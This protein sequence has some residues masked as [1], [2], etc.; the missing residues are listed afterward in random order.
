[1]ASA[2]AQDA[3][4][5]GRSA[6]RRPP[7]VS[8]LA[9]VIFLLMQPTPGSAQQVFSTEP[10]ALPTSPPS[11]IDPL[12]LPAALDLALRRN[13]ELQAAQQ[14]IRAM[15]AAVL[16][17][18]ARLNP[19]V[20]ASL[21]DLR[22]ETRETTVQLNQTL[23]LGGKRTARIG[24]AERGRDAA[25][26]D[27][28]VRRAEIRAIVIA[29]FF[30]LLAAQE[31]VRLAQSSVELAQR[32]TSVAANRVAAGKVSP[33]EETKARVAEANV[34]LELNQA[35]SE[36]AIA[37]Q[38]LAATWGDL[39][40]RF[41][42]AS[43]QL[44]TLPALPDSSEVAA[45]MAKAPALARARSEVDHRLAL[46][47][48]EK[49][50]RTPNLTVGAGVKRVEELGRNQAVLAVSIPLPLFDQNR[51]NLLEALHRA[52]KARDE[53]AATSIRLN[54]E[55]AQA[56]ERL[57]AAHREIGSLRQDILPGAQSAYDAATKGFEFGKF[58]FL[59]VLDAQ[60]TLLQAKFQYLRALSDAH[61][62]AAEI[63]RLLGENTPMPETA[64]P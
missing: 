64:A 51:G 53:L 27:L 6:H 55:L 42:Q 12:T 17:A 11:A 57:A 8:V 43:G 34:R 44:E 7:T 20:S 31:R 25:F 24:A 2:H 30:D 63:D 4:P 37:R 10:P 58:N 47:E 49:S 29:A 3:P 60:R 19:E 59:E 22:K 35:N 13:P 21:E 36:L 5:F 16:Q 15:D 50:R 1:M 40:P 28:A 32:A 38:R 23:E 33:V 18:G 41:G 61:R 45:R 14:E 62:L 9:F 46:A 52:D 48:V 54:S 56:Y 39:S 26:A